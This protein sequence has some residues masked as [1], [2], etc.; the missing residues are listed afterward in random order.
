[1]RR[2]DNLLLLYFVSVSESPLHALHA[3]DTNPK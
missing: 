3:D 2:F 1:M